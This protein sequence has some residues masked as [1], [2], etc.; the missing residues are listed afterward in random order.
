MLKLIMT[1]QVTDK[2]RHVNYILYGTTVE[3]G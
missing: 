3:L 1:A 2:H